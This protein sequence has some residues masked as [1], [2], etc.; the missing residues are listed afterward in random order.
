MTTESEYLEDVV[1]TKQ[2]RDDALL[3]LLIERIVARPPSRENAIIRTH[4]E[5]ALL[6]ERAQPLK[7]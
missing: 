2:V 3:T 4:L 6:W 5:T 7:L 1:G